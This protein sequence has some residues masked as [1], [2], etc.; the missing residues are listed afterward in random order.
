[1]LAFQTDYRDKILRY[2]LIKKNQWT[3][4]SEPMLNNASENT[5]KVQV[6]RL[7]NSLNNSFSLDETDKVM[8]ELLEAMQDKLLHGIIRVF[9]DAQLVDLFM[10]II[11]EHQ[12]SQVIAV[13][14]QQD[15]IK[16]TAS[17]TS[18]DVS[19]FWELLSKTRKIEIFNAMNKV[20]QFK[21]I[22]SDEYNFSTE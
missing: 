6:R 19:N 18:T 2:L 4:I 15:S 12:R 10:Q 13:L 5:K 8:S 22:S 1:M 11:D 9:S 16:T 21:F 3:D 17:K 20:E 14:A 7:I